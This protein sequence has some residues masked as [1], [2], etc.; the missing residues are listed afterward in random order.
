MRSPTTLPERR[1]SRITRKNLINS[2]LI[3]VFLGILA[4][5]P[6]GWFIHRFYAQQR[7]A[8]V[9]LCR[10]QNFGLSEADLQARCGQPF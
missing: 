6:I 2:L 1:E 5:A 7:T 9:L 8:Q 4:G 3:G 10:Q